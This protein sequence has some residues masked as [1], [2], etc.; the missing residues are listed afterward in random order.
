M[1]SGG[2]KIIWQSL[3]ILIKVVLQLTTPNLNNN[4][5][6][7]ASQRTGGATS[8]N[9]S[10]TFP[11]AS[12]LPRGNANLFRLLK[13]ET[14]SNHEEQNT[15]NKKDKM[16]MFVAYDADKNNVSVSPRPQVVNKGRRGDPRMHKAV[17]AR[18]ANPSLSLFHAL[19]IGG[20]KFPKHSSRKGDL[21]KDGKTSSRKKNQIYDS[22]NILLSQRKNQLSRRLR[23][24][25]RKKKQEEKLNCLYNIQSPL[26]EREQGMVDSIVAMASAIEHTGLFANKTGVPHTQTHPRLQLALNEIPQFQQPQQASSMYGGVNPTSLPLSPLGSDANKNQ[27]NLMLS[28]P[29]NPARRFQSLYCPPQHPPASNHLLMTMNNVSMSAT[30]NERNLMYNNLRLKHAVLMCQ[31]DNEQ[32]QRRALVTAACLARD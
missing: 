20:F 2:L 10:N 7:L 32:M 31:I 27:L 8:T 23:L 29:L 16:A 25:S 19:I 26:R 22:D 17:A 15:C 9:N 4:N 18:L 12:P 30:N 5:K 11:P 6:M 21:N 1:F 24:L 14:P 13:K 28:H 3:I